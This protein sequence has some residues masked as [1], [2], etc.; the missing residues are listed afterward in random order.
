MELKKTVRELLFG[1]YALTA[2]EFSL[3]CEFRT[4][5]GFPTDRL[6]GAT[7]NAGAA[8][9]QSWGSRVTPGELIPKFK[10]SRPNLRKLVY[11][12]AALPGAAV[13]FEPYDATKPVLVG[14]DAL[15]VLDAQEDYGDG[16][17]DRPR[18]RTLDGPP[19]PRRPNDGRRTLSG[20]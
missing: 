8:M 14:K 20:D 9:C 3:W 4:R 18:R 6:E 19:P 11:S 7:V 2:A 13:E 15:A 16:D 17:E 12:L 5:N 1:P 10:S